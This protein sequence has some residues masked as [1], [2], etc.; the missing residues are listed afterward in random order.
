MSGEL[1]RRMPTTPVRLS[2]TQHAGHA[3]DLARWEAQ[4]GSPLI[5]SVSGDGGYNEVVDGVMQA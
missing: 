3:R 2:P 1:E 4:T 5:I